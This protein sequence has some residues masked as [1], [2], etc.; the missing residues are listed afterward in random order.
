[1]QRL[2][3]VCVTLAHDYYTCIRLTEGETGALL[4]RSFPSESLEERSQQCHQRCWLRRTRGKETC[5]YRAQKPAC[6]N[7][8]GR[9]R[10]REAFVGDG[11]ALDQNKSS[12]IWCQ[13]PARLAFALY[14]SH[15]RYWRMPRWNAKRGERQERLWPG[16]GRAG[17]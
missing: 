5:F 2:R 16:L 17:I 4:E 7:M 1:M 3:A 12:Y 6:S 11:G 14:T 15:K 10:N 8:L 9:Y 13:K